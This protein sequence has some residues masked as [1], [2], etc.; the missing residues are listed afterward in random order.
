[1]IDLLE[2]EANGAKEITVIDV[3][4]INRAALGNT[5]YIESSEFYDDIYQRL[6]NPQTMN[7]RRLYPTH[8]RD[9]TVYW[10]MQDDEE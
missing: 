8:Y 2:L 7:S 10:I 5:F 4:P 9:N 1:M 3:S 6:R